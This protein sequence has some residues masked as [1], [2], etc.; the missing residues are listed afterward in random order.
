MQRLDLTGKKFGRLTA[1]ALSRIAP[2]PSGTRHFWKC[3]CD[4]GKVM[5]INK[6]RLTSGKTKS[7]GCLRREVTIR[8]FVKHGG[9][10]HAH[11]LYNTWSLMRFRCTNPK[12][13]AFKYYGG[14]GITLCDRWNDFANFIEDMGPK[15]SPSHSI[16]RIDNDGPYSPENCRWATP[17]EQSRNRRGMLDNP[18]T[19][20][21]SEN[22]SK[23]GNTE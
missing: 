7:C 20:K 6:F 5:E 2:A 10:N 16:D 13:A 21:A 18:L 8:Q 1:I 19:H 17:I 11:P 12:C 15:P 9:A 4:C 23:E 3:Q 22:S 14:R